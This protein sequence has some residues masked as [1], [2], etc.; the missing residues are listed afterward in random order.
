MWGC[1]WPTFLDAVCKAQKAIVRV[2]S[3]KGKYDLTGSVFKSL[4]LMN[5]QTAHKYFV[6]IT[7]FRILNSNCGIKE[8]FRLQDHHLNTRR[9]QLNLLCPLYRTTLF[10]NSILCNGPNI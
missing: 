5:I 1:T 8:L 4:K 9:N 10:N 7:I 3:Y 6:V 2:L